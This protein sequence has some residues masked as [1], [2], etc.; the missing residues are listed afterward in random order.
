M[1]KMNLIDIYSVFHPT[2]TNYTFFSA[3]CV[4]SPKQITP[5]V[6]KEISTKA[7]NN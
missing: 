4:L 2:A 3:A 1:N 5:W 6:I 7:K